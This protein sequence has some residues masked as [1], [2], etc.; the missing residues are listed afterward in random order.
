MTSPVSVRIDGLM[1]VGVAAAALVI[2]AGY[3][4]RQNKEALQ[5]FN[6][7]SDQNLVY[8]LVNSNWG[9]GF[10]IGE[11]QTVGT[12]LADKVEQAGQQAGQVD[13]ALA[14]LPGFDVGVKIGQWIR[15]WFD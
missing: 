13:E 12:W 9:W 1:V 14:Q 5:A 4:L 2:Y 3:K 7:A 15:G 8:Q 6:P 11:N 10:I